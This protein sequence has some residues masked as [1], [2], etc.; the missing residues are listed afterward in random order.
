M[1]CRS[2]ARRVLYT[3]HEFQLAWRK[4]KNVCQGPRPLDLDLGRKGPTFAWGLVE[5]PHHGSP[6]STTLE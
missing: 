3:A 6:P 1:R 2:R 4:S 5:L